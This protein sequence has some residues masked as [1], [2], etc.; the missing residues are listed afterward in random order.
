MKNNF[1]DLQTGT[2][3][4]SYKL[5]TWWFLASEIM[6]F[7]GVLVCFVLLRLNGASWVGEISHNNTQLGLLNTLI[8]LTSSFTIVESLTAYKKNDEAKF[9][10]FMAA[11]VGLGILFLVI[12]GIEYS[13]HIHEGYL[14]SKN[15]FWAFYFG[16]TGVHALHVIGGIVANASLYVTVTKSGDLKRYGHRSEA[17]GLYWHFVDLVWIF[18]FPLLYLG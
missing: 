13:I 1:E 5:G 4:P 11:T 15:L 12:K 9:K 2:T 8:L 18:L 16:M 10:K 6:V 17:C 14:P 7:G 3:I